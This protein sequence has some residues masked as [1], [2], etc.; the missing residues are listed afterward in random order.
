MPLPFLAGAAAVKI[1]AALLG[2]AAVG[3]GGTAIYKDSKHKKEIARLQDRIYDLQR[4][5]EQSQ[6]RERELINRIQKLQQEKQTL[7]QEIADQQVEIQKME[8]ERKAIMNK[9]KRN[10]NRFRQIIAKL[11]FR[12]KQLLAK[13]ESLQAALNSKDYT[14]TSE[15]NNLQ[16]KQ[17][18]VVNIDD[19]RHNA[20]E[21]LEDTRDK[22]TSLQYDIDELEYKLL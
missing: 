3:A 6:Q 18:K 5:L 7:L 22:V 9:I 14:L 8:K 11:M 13:V 12:E 2:G 17:A 16:R 21:E 1:G 20:E 15:K 19:Y 4:K 10:D